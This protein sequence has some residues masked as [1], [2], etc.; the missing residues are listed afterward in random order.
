[1]DFSNLKIGFVTHAR[2]P[3]RMKQVETFVEKGDLNFSFFYTA[4]KQTDRE[5]RI[6]NKTN[7][8]E[9]LLNSFLMFIKAIRKDILILSSYSNLQNI[10][11]AFLFRI[12][13]KPYFF[14]MDGISPKKIL[15]EENKIKLLLK[16]IVI[17]QA[18]AC[19]ANGNVSREYLVKKI[20]YDPEK[21]YNQF[22]TVDIEK[23]IKL[24][25]I[26]KIEKTIIYSGRFLKRKNIDHLVKA[27]SKSKCNKI[28]LL[29]IGDGEEKN[30][31]INLCKKNNI[32]CEFTGFVRNQDDLFKLYFKGDCLVLPSYDE[33]WGLVVN[34]AMAAGLPVIVSDECGCSM[35]LIDEGNNGYVFKAG[36]IG[37]LTNKIDLL[38]YNKLNIKNNSKQIIENWNFVNSFNSFCKMIEEY[39][40][41]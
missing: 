41:R 6:K 39:Y 1:M 30:N 18:K 8:D 35:D 3:Y 28:K 34:E 33:P 9:Y 14:C 15:S 26:K 19:F 5:W 20:G 24:E 37:D 32:D 21:I 22:L 7:I 17:M 40:Q 29:I 2:A 38:Y 16:K 13:G 31:I 11:L 4:K 12:I 27:I 25:S 10:V 23:I 36:D